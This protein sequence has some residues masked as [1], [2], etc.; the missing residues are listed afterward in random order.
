MAEEY[1][2]FTYQSEILSKDLLEYLIADKDFNLS[3][4]EWDDSKITIPD[5]LMT[6]W[7][8]DVDPVTIEELTSRQAFGSGIFDAIMESIHN[9]LKIEYESG[10]ITGAEYA[11]TY[12]RLTEAGLTNAVQFCLQKNQAY[13]NGVLAQAQAVTAGIQ[14]QLAALTAKLQFAKTKAEALHIAAEYALTTMKL[15]TEDAQHALVCKQQEVTNAQIAQTIA[16]TATEV[17]RTAL[18]HEQI[19][20]QTAQTASEIERA[21]LTHEQIATQVEQTAGTHEQ[22][23]L[24]KAQIISEGERAAVTHE[25]IA[26]TQE[27]TNQTREQI[28]QIRE[29]AA[30]THEQIAREIEQTALTHKQTTLTSAQIDQVL[31]QNT[32]LGYDNLAKKYQAMA[33]DPQP[34]SEHEGTNIDFLTKDKNIKHIQSQMNVEASQVSLYKQQKDSYKRND[35]R[36]VAELFSGTYTAMK[37]VDEGLAIPKAFSGASINEVLQNLKANVDLGEDSTNQTFTWLQNGVLRAN[38]GAE[39]NSTDETIPEHNSNSNP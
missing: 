10:R 3:D 1:T 26:Q 24:V 29:Q 33:N 19:N 6:S 17:E 16:Q 13:Y 39:E 14:A 38:T 34:S 5:D 32:G 12:T 11:T 4:V 36:K 30:L 21:A 8:K 35:E 18:T 22:T 25:Q 28:I 7:K 2:G 31:T 27:Q 23:N 15:S 9:H 37:A 20:T